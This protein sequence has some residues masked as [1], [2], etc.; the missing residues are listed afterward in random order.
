MTCGGKKKRWHGIKLLKTSERPLWWSG[1]D[2]KS[3]SQVRDSDNAKKRMKKYVK[4][5]I[6]SISK[7]KS[8][9]HTSTQILTSKHYSYNREQ[10]SFEKWKCITA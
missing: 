6:K 10:T 3:V 4:D 8:N 5:R 2:N 1:N 7:V 9:E